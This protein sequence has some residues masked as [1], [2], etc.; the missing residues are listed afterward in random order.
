MGKLARAGITTPQKLQTY[1]VNDT[2][3][4]HLMNFGDNGLN[5]ITLKG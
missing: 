2:F 1:I 5:S 3:N 4:S